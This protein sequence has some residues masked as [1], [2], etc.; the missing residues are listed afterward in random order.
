MKISEETELWR[1]GPIITNE[2]DEPKERLSAIL[3]EKMKL[4]TATTW[5]ISPINTH[6]TIANYIINPL[7]P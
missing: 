5:T 6:Y 7:M 4:M 1:C 3:K 2:P